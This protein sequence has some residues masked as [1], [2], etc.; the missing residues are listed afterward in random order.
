MKIIK[1]RMSP[2]IS[3]VIPNRDDSKYIERCIKSVLEQSVLPDEIIFI[4][5]KST[6]N[7][8]D[9]VKEIQRNSSFKNFKVLE[10]PVNYG[11]MKT[12]NVGLKATSCDYVIFLAS[13]DSLSK[14]II[15][16]VKSDIS[17]CSKSPGV[18]SALVKLVDS[19]GNFLGTHRSPLVR[20]ETS[21]ILPGDCIKLAFRLGNWFTGSTTFFNVKL[22][23][24]IG[25][26]DDR[27]KGLADYI[28][29]LTLASLEGA[30]F[31]PKVFGNMTIH[32]NNYLHKTLVDPNQIEFYLDCINERGKVTSPKLFKQSKFR[33]SLEKRLY[34]ASIREQLRSTNRIE[35]PLNT[36]S[37]LRFFAY[38]SRFPFGGRMKL[39][40]A[41]M[42]IRPSDVLFAI[43]FRMKNCIFVK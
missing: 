33:I 20:L 26:I 34:F 4:D 12:L 6:D 28:A 13:N 43:Y 14:G 27:I 42:L 11:V 35:F 21:Y 25:G 9:L 29:A 24:E 1:G 5:D 15:E 32:E 3:V 7:S 22:L 36:P 40:L 19:E 16:E 18:W 38:L 31:N 30:I 37:F 2:K 8:L 17:S 10:N 23:K 41:Y 39:Y